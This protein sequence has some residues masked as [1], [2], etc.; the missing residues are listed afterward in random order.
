MGKLIVDVLPEPLQVTLGHS[1]LHCEGW[2]NVLRQFMLTR[3]HREG[4][5]HCKRD[6]GIQGHSGTLPTWGPLGRLGGCHANVL[7]L[8]VPSSG[9]KITRKEPYFD[10]FKHL[11]FVSD[12]PRPPPFP[13]AE[14][15]NPISF[16]GVII[17]FGAVL[18]RRSQMFDG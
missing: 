10:G 15:V 12:D 11:E 4:V 1:K 9:L 8:D 5:P 13:K 6:P 18:A 14:I 3:D 7:T 2:P 16:Y 17:Q